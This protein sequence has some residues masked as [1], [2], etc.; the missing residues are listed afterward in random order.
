MSFGFYLIVIHLM[1]ANSLGIFY[2][3]QLVWSLTTTFA[4]LSLPS[5]FLRF[6]TGYV[7][8]NRIAEAR[9]LFRRSIMIALVIILI[10]VPILFLFAPILSTWLFGP[11]QNRFLVYL[12]IVDFALYGLGTF[13][14]VSLNATRAFNRVGLLQI[15][16]G[17]LRFGLAV[18]LFFAGFGVPSLIYGW[19]VADSFYLVFYSYFS[20]LFW[21]GFEVKNE[22]KKVV[23]FSLPFFV[24]SGIVLV[25]QNVDRLFV[26]KYLGLD[27]LGIYGTLLIAAGVP[28][29]LPSSVGTALLP[30]VIKIEEK[31]GLVSDVVTNSIR[32]I[33][34]LTLPIL[35][36][37]AS[38]SKPLISAVL[39]PNFA[40]G[41]VAFAVLTVGY[42]AMSPDIPLGQVLTAKKKTRV[43]AIQQVVSGV[44]LAGLALVLIPQFFLTGAALAYVLARLAGFVFILPSLYRLKLFKVEWLEYVKIVASSSIILL[45]TVGMESLT[46][47]K[48]ALLPLYLLVGVAVGLASVKLLKVFRDE[49]YHVMMDFMPRRFRDVASKAWRI[50][51][52][53]IQRESLESNSNNSV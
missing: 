10:T 9:Y 35:S 26:L 15:V 14:S 19:I 5:G 32:Y 1:S 3:L 12:T 20:R 47:Y 25:L 24:S 43:L 22:L 8:T 17:A 52:L 23:T 38:L 27:E 40:F 37:V 34:I 42:A 46:S 2:T 31:D 11:E 30:A 33:T 51:G 13:L 4:F 18:V 49:D 28:Q 39:G 48:L 53:P 21:F 45:V 29:L 16:Y 36:L 41:W 44:V 7:Q 50:L 6:V